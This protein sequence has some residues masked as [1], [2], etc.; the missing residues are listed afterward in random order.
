MVAA[1][2]FF[3]TERD[4]DRLFEYLRRDAD[5]Y[6]FPWQAM[7]VDAPTF[8]D[9][10]TLPT[11]SPSVMYFGIL[12]ARLGPVRFLNKKPNRLGKGGAKSFVFNVMAW[13]AMR[14]PA[15]EGIVD[16]E[17]ALFWQR[18]TRDSDSCLG[19][20]N[21]GSQAE[22][23]HGIS[24]EYQR[25]ASRVMSWVRRSGEKVIDRAELMPA[26][27][28]FNIRTNGSLNARFAL[29]DAMSFLRAGG[30]GKT[31]A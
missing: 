23:M 19:N 13:E 11:L 12:N 2:H 10:A 26:A 28:G 27:R 31:W 1:V 16:W 4:E 3:A 22:A 25:W 15:G 20:G 17:A 7:P 21:I 24:E 29:P 18:C 6:L 30:A 9:P 8:I 5:V 14:P